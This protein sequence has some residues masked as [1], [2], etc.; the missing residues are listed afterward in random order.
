[1]HVSQYHATSVE[2]VLRLKTN[3]FPIYIACEYEKYIV[4]NFVYIL[5]FFEI[6]EGFFLP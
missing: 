4:S 3:Q 6:I 5:S 2:H 1:M